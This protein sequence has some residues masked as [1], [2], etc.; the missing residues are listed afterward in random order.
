[1]H[2]YIYARTHARTHAHVHTC[3]CAMHTSNTAPYSFCCLD[4]P[5][6]PIIHL[7]ASQ[8]ALAEG[9]YLQ[10]NC[11]SQGG[12]PAP[13]ITWKRDGIPLEGG[14]PSRQF[15]IT[16][17]VLVLLLTRA[18]NHANL[19]CHVTSEAM[20]TEKMAAQVILVQCK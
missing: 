12:N 5:G 3:I 18:D 19:T 14:R 13:D 17:S 9:V 16:T 10:V 7:N 1:M 20:A 11:S 8:D 4:A 2:T 6:D 15:G